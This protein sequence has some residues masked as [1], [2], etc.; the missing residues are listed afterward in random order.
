LEESLALRAYTDAMQHRATTDWDREWVAHLFAM[1]DR[2]DPP[3]LVP[4]AP[5]LPYSFTE[6]DLRDYLRGWPDTRPYGWRE[7]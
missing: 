6:Y 5:E 2:L 3:N 4:L 7:S 1:A